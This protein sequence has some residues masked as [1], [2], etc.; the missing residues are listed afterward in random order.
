MRQEDPKLKA[1]LGYIASPCL[2]I[3]SKLRVRMELMVEHLP[4]MYEV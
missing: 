3:Q 2:K 1:S 4:S